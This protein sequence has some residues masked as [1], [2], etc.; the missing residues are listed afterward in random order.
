[1]KKIV[2]FKLYEKLDDHKRRVI[3]EVINI[4]ESLEFFPVANDTLEDIISKLEAIN[5]R[6]VDVKAALYDPKK[7]KQYL[8]DGPSAPGGGGQ[9]A[10]KDLR[11]MLS[12]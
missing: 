11:R 6:P 4:L 1:M 2:P 8:I 5:I 3:Q 7:H 9:G 12:T 10:L